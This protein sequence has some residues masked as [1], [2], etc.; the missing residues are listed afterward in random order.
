MALILGVMMMF[1][2]IPQ[3][4]FMRELFKRDYS[5]KYYSSLPF[6]LSMNLIEL[7]YLTLVSTICVFCFYW[8]TG[9]GDSPHFNGFFF[10]L[11]FTMF[12]FYCHSCGI[13]IAYVLLLLLMIQLV[14]C[15]FS[16][17]SP[18]AGAAM[19]LLSMF[20]AFVFLLAGTFI[21]P[22]NMP[23]FWHVWGYPL[24]PFKY[25]SEG[26]VSTGLSPVTVHCSSKDFYH[27]YAPPNMTCGEYTTPFLTYATGYINNPAASGSDLCEYCMYKSG[28]D[29]LATL[30]WNVNNRWRDFGLL[31]TYWVFNMFL[32]VIF[33]HIF[34]KQKR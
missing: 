33:V 18:H 21:P 11:I 19:V 6:A 30:G 23:H 4:L 3:F 2:A 14:T 15:L 8:S 20:M 10:W 13:F 27:F 31:T 32:G 24:D 25:F 28:D 7:P 5:S 22:A 29:Y 26:I 17:M 12:I 1:G 16:A 9:L 34:R